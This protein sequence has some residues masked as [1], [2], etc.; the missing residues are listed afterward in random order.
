MRDPIVLDPMDLPAG[1][2]LTP[3]EALL[4]QGLCP[5]CAQPAAFEPHQSFDGSLRCLACGF[6]FTGTGGG[7]RRVE[8]VHARGDPAKA[9]PAAAHLPAATARTKRDPEADFRREVVAEQ[10]RR[11]R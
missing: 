4:W 1:Q 6:E 10:R 2:E 7:E 5:H 11:D 8:Q 3:A 9:G